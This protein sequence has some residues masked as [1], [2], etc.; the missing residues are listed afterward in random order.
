[1]TRVIF[2]DRELEREQGPRIHYALSQIAVG[3]ALGH[4]QQRPDEIVVHRRLAGGRSGS[5]VLE[6]TVGWGNQRSSKVVKV[7]PVR[8][9]REEYLAFGQH[10]RQAAAAFAPIE[11][12]TPAVVD[13]GPAGRRPAAG[14]DKPEA[15][16]YDH[17]SRFV[18]TPGVSPRTLEDRAR[19]AVEAGGTAVDEVT[20]AIAALVEAARND[21][22]ARTRRRTGQEGGLAT[23]MNRRLG[24][25]L[26]IEVDRSAKPKGEPWRLTL[27][28]LTADDRGKFPTRYPQELYDTSVRLDAPI[29]AGD[30]IRLFGLHAVRWGDRLMADPGDRR[31]LVEVVAGD[32]PIA[33]VAGKLKEGEPF[34]VYGKVRSTR[35]HAHHARLSADALQADGDVLRGE[36]VAVPDPF[37]ALHRLLS[38]DPEKGVWT[39]AH[40]D[41]N[42]RNVLLVGDK[43]CLIDYAFTADGQPIFA[44]FARLEGSLARDALP[45]GWSW[46]RHVRLQRL[47]ATACRLGDQAADR[48]AGLLASEDPSL[49]AAFRLLWSVRRA[50]REVYPASAKGPWWR[51][52]LLQLFL[53][54][55]LI[56]KWPDQSPAT[57][58]ATA[59]MAG[60]AA[61]ALDG[62]GAYRLWSEEEFRAA[63]NEILEALDRDP[64]HALEELAQ[65]ATE[66]DG[67]RLPEELRKQL[68]QAVERVRAGVVR[69]FF[70][71]P[72]HKTLVRL[73]QDHDVFISLRAYIGLTGRLH[74]PVRPA[75]GRPRTYTELLGGD[76]A[77]EDGGDVT[78]DDARLALLLDEAETPPAEQGEGRDVLDLLTELDEVVVLGDA[79]AGKSTVARELEY[80]LAEAVVAPDKRRLPPRMPVVVRASTIADE[81]A[82]S[83]AGEPRSLAGVLFGADA[84]TW[85]TELLD[86]GGVHVTVDA[87]NE[88]DDDPKARVVDWLTKLRRRY[89][90]TPVAACHRLYGYVPGLLPFPT[91]TLD[92]VAPEQAERYIHDYLRENE[93]QDHAAMATRL[94]RLLL[95]PDQEQVRDL[96]QTPL[97]LWM[98]ASRYRLTGVRPSNRGQLFRDFSRWYMEERH[99][100]E[101]DEHVEWQFSYDDKSKL[102]EA[103]AAR[104]VELG[105]TEIAEQEVAPPLVPDSV[106]PRWREVLEE[107]VRSEMVRRADGK[108]HFLHQSFQEYFAARHFL[109]TA[110][111]DPEV[112]RSRVHSYRWHDTFTI[113]LG[114][115]GEH[116]EVV[117]RVIQTVL[118]VNP[119]LTARCLRVAERPE[120]ELLER[121]VAEQEATLRDQRAGDFAQA[122]AATALAEYG[123]GRAHDVLVALA[124]DRDAPVTSRAE[125]I[126]RLAGRLEKERV[127]QR[128][129]DL[130]NDVVPAL[131]RVFEEPAPTAVLEAAIAAAGRA[132]LTALSDYVRELVDGNE[133][134]SLARAAYEALEGLGVVP[135]QKLKARYR[136]LCEARLPETE[137]ELFAASITAEIE[138][139]QEERVAILEQLADPA[140][141]ELLLRR[142][143]ALGIGDQVAWLLDQA[144]AATGEVPEPVR[145]A[146]AVLREPEPPDPSPRDRWLRLLAEPD[147]PTGVAA[148]HRIVREDD[149]PEVEE[150]MALLDPALEPA[151]L[152]A[153]AAL[154]NEYWDLEEEAEGRLLDRAD[155]VVRARAE[156]AEG[157]EA[158]E[159]LACLVEA[160]RELDDGRGNRLAAVVDH[161]LRL[162]EEA[163]QPN[164]FPWVATDDDT[165][166]SPEDYRTLL[167]GDADQMEAAVRQL[168]AF[169]DWSLTRALPID[170]IEL[171]DEAIELLGRAAREE[172]DPMGQQQFAG[173]VAKV[174]AI[175]LL[176]WLLEIVDR[177]ELAAT[178]MQHDDTFAARERSARALVLL[179]IGC[180]ARRVD[181][182]DSAVVDK[183]AQTLRRFAGDEDRSTAVDAV[184][185]LAY[186]G[187]WKTVL[188]A[189]GPGEP[190]LHEVAANVCQHWVPGADL[191]RVTRWITCRLRDEPGLDPAARSTLQRVKEANERRLGHVVPCE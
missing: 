148:V 48:F 136:S 4:W 142:R 101:R 25:V 36:G 19:D 51:E 74:E 78:P 45:P 58:Q 14:D 132:R 75:V 97:F 63:A 6:V 83:D 88:L 64:E 30:R 77:A 27:G 156:T 32:P 114:F 189:L 31:L 185:G 167:V 150:V 145:P 166:L 21:L 5:E 1:M 49:G 173:A 147:L 124:T 89:P 29:T 170:P 179:A 190:W 96:A 62:R 177:P 95:D 12:G 159:A 11:A 35:A 130:R 162:R 18:G 135:G 117:T 65:V 108:L 84:G 52:Y 41:L 176:P 7:G 109:R 180:L 151:K 107:I 187:E 22:W 42:P 86:V 73:Q 23:V 61:E 139:L 20:T 69:G 138:R 126:D 125:A 10:L 28:Q 105:S 55:H 178:S 33:E 85:P 71:D 67:R 46:A 13:P 141:L 59:A 43:A 129:R 113:L 54:A 172:D 17:A 106:G 2:D 116:P 24:P 3:Q 122:Q 188:S 131:T 80:R 169:G 149:L 134:W 90:R 174:G 16:V 56:L 112:V 115:A 133:P 38:D 8:E 137:R 181:Q 153:L 92:K 66:L 168:R 155:E 171:D 163:T 102:L 82:S 144:A 127:E 26:E 119:T 111:D 186:L 140:H 87:L 50:A 60:V 152:C 175:G 72:A 165:Y 57:L 120:P 37:A 121:F 164:Q 103:V 15:L 34:E 191:E 44:D 143:F 94:V 182:P 9:L 110:A 104:L 100:A 158:T 118:E 39:V 98:I 99:H 79:G 160:I 183:A 146:W 128:R 40:G 76:V 93:V 47:L 81:L 157:P 161:R 68:D 91:V 184:T 154:L 70:R 53:F 123:R